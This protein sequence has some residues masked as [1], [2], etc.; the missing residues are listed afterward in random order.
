VSSKAR[1]S[2]KLVMDALRAG[3]LA[4]IP[5]PHS[6]YPLPRM[7]ED[8]KVTLRGVATA[9]PKALADAYG[10]RGTNP[11]SAGR[12]ASTAIIVGSSTGG[13]TAFETFAR[14][15]PSGHP[16]VLL[17][18]HLPVDFVPRFV[19]RLEESL[20]SHVSVAR[21]GEP[22]LPDHIYVAP[23]T[24]HLRLNA[25]PKRPATELLDSETVNF[26]RPSVDVLMLSVAASPMVKNTV[27]VMLT[28]MGADGAKG[29]LA[30]R[31]AG[32]FTLGQDEAS[33]VVYGMPRAAFQLGG[34]QEQHPPERLAKRALEMLAQ[35][36]RP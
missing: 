8:L 4:V 26:H 9:Q 23:A 24:H 6:E 16:C 20:P 35:P 34:V 17:A 15:L 3:A 32:A 18:Q 27:G 14:S 11:L 13:T 12:A 19:D 29:M 36:V 1:R 7:V 2:P 10:S 5:K 25:D 30:M 28:G 31:K 21:G 22:L 33:S